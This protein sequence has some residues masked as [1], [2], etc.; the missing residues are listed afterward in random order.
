[1]NWRRGLASV[2][3][4]GWQPSASSA[5]SFSPL[6]LQ[7]PIWSVQTELVLS[8]SSSA[9]SC[10]DSCAI[11]AGLRSLCKLFSILAISDKCTNLCMGVVRHGRFCG[12]YDMSVMNY[13]VC[14]TSCCGGAYCILTHAAH[15][16]TQHGLLLAPSKSSRLFPAFVLD[17]GIVVECLVAHHAE[18]CI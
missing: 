15:T 13:L 18:S 16:G 2:S 5:C 12:L 6:P 7:W 3:S 10:S 11:F 4:Q 1:M 8:L 17:S 14:C 9:V